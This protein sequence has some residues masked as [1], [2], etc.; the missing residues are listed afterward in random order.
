MFDLKQK[1]AEIIE[2]ESEFNKINM[3][4]FD[5]HEQI[6][7]SLPQIIEKFEAYIERQ[8]NQYEKDAVL[9]YLS[10]NQEE[11][12]EYQ[13][14]GFPYAIDG[15][16]GLGSMGEFEFDMDHWFPYMT[17]CKME[18]VNRYTDLYISKSGDSYYGYINSDYDYISVKN[19][20]DT[21]CEALFIKL[22]SLPL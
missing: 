8:L 4:D 3:L 12:I 10:W 15:V 21:I 13:S 20:I 6:F 11:T 22:E 1:V 16:Y 2:S 7:Y 14:C 17:D 9:E 5:W 19:D 18:A